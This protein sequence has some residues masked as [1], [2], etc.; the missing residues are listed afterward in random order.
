MAIAK[1]GDINLE[2]YDE[3]E[4][5]P[6]LMIRGLGA[7]CTTWGE[8]LLAPLR[9]R[10]RTIRLSNRGTGLS[11]K[12]AGATSIRTMADDAAALLNTLR[13]ERAH[14]FGVSMGGMI[15]QELALGH[16]ERVDRLVLGCT[17]AGGENAVRPSSDV[18]ALLMPQAGV[19]VEEQLRKTWPTL[20]TT[21][22]IEERR[23]FLEEMLRIDMETPTPIETMVKQIAAIG[24]FDTYGR[25]PSIE[26]TTLVLHGDADVLVPTDNARIL[27]ERIPGS[28]LEIVP[29]AGHM[30]FWEHPERTA[31]ILTSFLLQVP[32]G[33]E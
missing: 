26:A 12:P 25:L 21:R 33:H 8:P 17:A 24:E 9:E 4:G 23:E 28:T 15:A 30:F 19:P 3:G 13:I 22:T 32:A 10:F 5:P 2:Y 16:P 6:L 20:M 29:E 1:C 31:A 18:T 11:D 14:V 27:H 7:Q